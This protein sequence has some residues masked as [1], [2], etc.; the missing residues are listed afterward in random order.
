MA[1]T[2]RYV[3]ICPECAADIRRPKPRVTAPLAD[4]SVGL[5]TCLYRADGF[6]GLGVTTDFAPSTLADVRRKADHERL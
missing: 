6:E 5:V 4:P 1:I 2:P 3:W